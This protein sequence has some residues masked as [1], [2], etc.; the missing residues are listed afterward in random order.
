[1]RV[2]G[3]FG[4]EGCALGYSREAGRVCEHCFVC[5]CVCVCVII[6]K[7]HNDCHFGI[8]NWGT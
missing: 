2:G 5:V 1:M 6:G 8:N 4:G 3:L 7:K